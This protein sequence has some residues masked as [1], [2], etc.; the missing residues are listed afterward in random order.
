MLWVRSVTGAIQTYLHR[1]RRTLLRRAMFQ[2]HLWIGFAAALYVALIGISGSILVWK[3]ELSAASQSVPTALQAGATSIGPE[4]AV[5]EAQRAAPRKQ[6]YYLDFPQSSA[7]FYVVYL[8]GTSM[9]TTVRV[10]AGSGAVLDV[11]DGQH[12]WL[13]LVMRFHYFVSAA[14]SSRQ[15]KK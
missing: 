7:P 6:P 14:L 13:N 1:P 4:R 3:H 11:D 12:G 5:M 15:H 2:V 10:H 8:R 9:R